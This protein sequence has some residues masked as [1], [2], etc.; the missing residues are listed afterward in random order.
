MIT[1]LHGTSSSSDVDEG[2]SF[3]KRRGDKVVPVLPILIIP[4][5]MSSGL[6]IRESSAKRG[7]VG[8]RLWINLGSLGIQSVHLFRGGKGG[9]TEVSVHHTNNTNDGDDQ[10]RQEEDREL[11]QH[12]EYKSLWLKHMCLLGDMVTESPGIVVRNI[13]GLKGVDYLT[14]GALTNFVSYVFGPVIKALVARAGYVKGFNLDAAPYDW[15][16]PPSAL[17]SRDKYFTNTMK[18]V[19][20]M[21]EDSN[22][23]PVVLLCHSLGCKTGHYFLNFAKQKKGQGWLDKY[24]HTYMP[25][26]SPHLGAPKALRSVVSGDKMSL[27]AFL[28][29]DEALVLGRSLGSGP[30]LFPSTV[31]R[32]GISNAFVRKEGCLTVEIVGEI[33]VLPLLKDRDQSVRPKALKVMVLFGKS[34]LGSSL[35]KITQDYRVRFDLHEKFVFATHPTKPVDDTM[36]GDVLICLCEPGIRAGKNKKERQKTYCCTCQDCLCCIFCCIPWMIWK[37]IASVFRFLWCFARGVAETTIITVDALAKASGGC[38]VLATSN[39]LSVASTIRRSSAG[40]RRNV[41]KTV[42]STHIELYHRDLQKKKW[43]TS[44]SPKVKCTVK[45]TWEPWIEN[46]LLLRRDVTSCS[47]VSEKAD[48]KSI[49]PFRIRDKRSGS[50]TGY[51]EIS[52]LDLLVREDLQRIPSLLGAVYDSDSLGP[53]TLSSSEVPPVRRVKAIYGTNLPTEVGAVYRRG[54]DFVD[55]KRKVRNVFVLDT[56]AE[57]VDETGRYV[58]ED[59]IIKETSITAGNGNSSKRND[60]GTR[61]SGDGTVPYWSLRHSKEWGKDGS[62]HVEVHELDRADHRE[63]LADE[64]FHDLVIDYATRNANADPG[65]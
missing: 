57:L 37:L 6:E 28:T 53:R 40:S 48:K 25:V 12:M 30:W 55:D 41:A 65:V 27:D 24:V 21:Y 15:R 19:E 62:C 7:W 2:S 58:C 34:S 11:H 50:S 5:F 33:N 64:R 29:D 39:M 38:T 44:S 59:G 23:M 49:A 52:G 56:N 60:G 13:G 14:P 61:V 42:A 54:K 45:M 4:G 32:D 1:S 26:G 31:P 22:G 51:A 16:L 20:K 36:S 10:K 18:R 63:I 3:P 8:K 9:R 47:P 17:E 43:T 46:A 35:V